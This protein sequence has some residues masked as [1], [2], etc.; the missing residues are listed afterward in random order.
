M[1]KPHFYLKERNSSSE[2]PIFMY[3]YI[4][5]MQFKF[6]TG[7]KIQPR[8][9]SASKERVLGRYP[10]SEAY[11]TKLDRM[12]DV[13]LSVYEEILIKHGAFRP[14]I[15][16][17]EL[18]I[19]KQG[20]VK[21][22]ATIKSFIDDFIARKAADPRI[23]HITIKKYKT[24]VKHFLD[25]CESNHIYS[26]DGINHE[27]WRDFERLLLLRKYASN[28]I[29]KTLSNI[30]T[31]LRDAHKRG[32]SNNATFLSLDIETK[33]ES[34]KSVY[35]SSE[36]IQRLYELDYSNNKRLEKARDLFLLGAYTGLRYSDFSRLDTK[37]IKEVNG[38][39]LI[40]FPSQKTGAEVVIPA[41][42]N[43][44][45]I[46]SKHGGKA[47]KIS[48]QKLRD[49][50]KEI[51]ESCGFLNDL[52]N[53]IRT[54]GGQRVTKTVPRWQLVGTHTARRSFATNAYLEG[55]DA[56]TIMQITG[57]KTETEFLKYIAVTKQQNALRI[58][59]SVNSYTREISAIERLIK[60]SDLIG[61]SS[62]E[63][64]TLRLIVSK[65]S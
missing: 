44:L 5:K 16:R 60:S 37:Y 57:H 21:E 32:V 13:A 22:D 52:V 6:S 54:V 8:F 4:S 24:S 55:W 42:K 59:Q 23:K 63:I 28:T 31:I 34:A 30:R 15:L 9:W 20:R 41:H 50:L 61:L 43:L 3:W 36:E 25:F 29:A 2:T 17:Q 46:L 48:D 58:A 7:I 10:R 53:F 65:L 51:C 45:L 40:Y 49:Y 14:K 11:N 38:H 56:I 35:L 64:K 62:E 47:P 18:N 27:R 33:R 39:K 19:V 12:V 1:P 26:L